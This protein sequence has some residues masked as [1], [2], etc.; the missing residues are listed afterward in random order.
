MFEF[1]V[2]NVLYLFLS[3]TLVKIYEERKPE[4]NLWASLRK[5]KI[6]SLREWLTITAARDFFIVKTKL[7]KFIFSGQKNDLF[8]QVMNLN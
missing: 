7:S 1:Y 8:N 3:H 5:G 2:T 6:V 4:N